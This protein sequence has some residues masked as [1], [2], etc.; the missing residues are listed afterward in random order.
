LQDPDIA[1]TLREGLEVLIP[2]VLNGT[3]GPELVQV[4][5]KSCLDLLDCL[6]PYDPMQIVDSHI[7][8]SNKTTA[9][10]WMCPSNSECGKQGCNPTAQF[11]NDIDHCFFK[12]ICLILINRVCG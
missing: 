8:S 9:S 12:G 2:K 7:P 6:L 4:V 10:L 5:E 3:P 1:E 11:L